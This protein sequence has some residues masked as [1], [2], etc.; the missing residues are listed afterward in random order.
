MGPGR[1]IEQGVRA[2]EF[3]R[4]RRVKCMEF[5]SMLS[6][7]MASG[8]RRLGSSKRKCL[9]AL[10]LYAWR[11]RWASLLRRAHHLHIWFLIKLLL[12]KWFCF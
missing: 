3:Q 4:N 7:W 9:V 1:R 5:Q 11:G 2:E 10:W 8:A 12:E 6:S